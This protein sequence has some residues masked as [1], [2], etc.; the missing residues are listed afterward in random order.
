MTRKIK[1]KPALTDLYK[2]RSKSSYGLTDLYKS[3]EELKDSEGKRTTFVVRMT[4]EESNAL[5]EAVNKGMEEIHKV[6]AQLDWVM[7][8]IVREQQ[9][10]IDERCRK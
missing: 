6:P 5:L 7:T 10:L 3:Q 1:S 4:L 2:I 8:R 9:A